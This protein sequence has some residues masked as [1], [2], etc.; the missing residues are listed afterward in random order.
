MGGV[1]YSIKLVADYTTTSTSEGDWAVF[2]PV[3]EMSCDVTSLALGNGG[4]IGS[5]LTFPLRLYSQGPQKEYV[6]CL[7]HGPKR[8]DVNLAT[9][10]VMDVAFD[11][12]PRMKAIVWDEALADAVEMLDHNKHRSDRPGEGDDDDEH[13]ENDDNGGNGGNDDNDD[14]DGNDGNDDF[15]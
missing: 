11:L 1:A 3:E 6:L 5:T 15:I 4:K 9:A 8:L 13:D 2:V 10:G 12:H 14:N 7:S